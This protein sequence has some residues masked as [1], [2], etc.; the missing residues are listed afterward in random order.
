MIEP[1][2]HE[3]ISRITT[4]WDGLLSAHRSDGDDQRSARAEI[5]KRY[6]FSIC[7]YISS[8]ARDSDV[9][10][11]LA[12]EFALRFIRGDYK[13]VDPNKG[14]FRDY[15]KSSL[16]NLVMDHFRKRRGNDATLSQVGQLEDKLELS[17][18]TQ[19][20]ADFHTHWRQEL[21]QRAWSGLRELEQKKNNYYFTVL[22]FRA[23]HTDW[24][25][26]EIA[27]TLSEQIDPNVS[28]EWVRQKL[29]RARRK[30]A[31]LL[32]A[33]VR[34]SM[35]DANGDD[36]EEELAELGLKKYLDV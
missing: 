29:H 17:Q 13:A 3:R 32:I 1:N 18:L 33:E 14:R 9:A 11:D 6:S 27:Q 7:Q 19:M 36:I 16:R 8:I 25:S 31:E 28:A 34:A 12:Q 5:L 10:D 26:F 15:L 20:E 23:E 35:P 22:H 2:Q 4:N 24:G 30:F 21:L